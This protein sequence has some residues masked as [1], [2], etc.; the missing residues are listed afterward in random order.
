MDSLELFAVAGA[1]LFECAQI[2]G[3][4][5]GV[6]LRREPSRSSGGWWYVAQVSQVSLLL[7][8]NEHPAGSVS[9][10]Q[11]APVSAA[12]SQKRPEFGSSRV[13]R[14]RLEAGHLSEA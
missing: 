11:G 6:E 4:A 5:L 14:T 13:D 7:R 9:R 2:V 3:A 8:P 10:L 1:D 12:R